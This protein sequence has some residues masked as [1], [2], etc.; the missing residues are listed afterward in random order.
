MSHTAIVTG[1]SRGFG[2][3]I[4]TA[5][6][7]E[8]RHVVGVSRSAGDLADLR[9]EVGDRFTPVTADVAESTVAERLIAEVR[10][11][12][13]VLITGATPHMAPLT[14]QTWET[15]SANWNVDTRHVFGWTKAALN[16]PL[17]PGSVVVVISSGAALRGSPLSGGYAGAKAA[18]KFV[19]DY[20]AE[21]AGRSGLGI[22]FITL[23]PML[24]PTG[25]GRAGVR[26]YAAQQDVPEAEFVDGLQPV[27]TPEIVAKTVVDL[28]T[29]SDP[30]H[31]YVLTGAGAA[32]L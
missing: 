18:V 15:F 29:A 3:A 30:S 32:P 4:A 11:G 5:L 6:A 9:A 2:R 14:A 12:L 17:E 28:S 21:E 8:G 22:C 10:P 25:V 19:A 13:L 1:A 31:G 20:A 24:S 27:L 16:Q 7:A 23:Y 26:A